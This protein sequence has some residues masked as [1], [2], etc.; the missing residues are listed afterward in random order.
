[1]RKTIANSFTNVLLVTLIGFT[2]VAGFRSYR[3]QK[4]LADRSAAVNKPFATLNTLPDV[5]IVILDSSEQK[6]RLTELFKG[7]C[8]VIEFFNSSCP[9]CQKQAPSWKSIFEVDKGGIILP[10]VW[11]A[12]H[13]DDPGAEQFAAAFKLSRPLYAIATPDEGIRLRIFRVP[14]TYVV[15]PGPIL[16]GHGPR[17]P[18]EGIVVTDSIDFRRTCPVNAIGKSDAR[19]IVHELPK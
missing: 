3:S 7:K 16:L 9:A 15:A 14:E 11:I 10:V 17:R 18:D 6:I 2:A 1:M 5:E 4:Q 8:G 13:A 12:T 19:S